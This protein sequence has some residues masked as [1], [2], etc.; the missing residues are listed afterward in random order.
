M[1]KFTLVFALILIVGF[2]AP[3]TSPVYT[4]SKQPASQE[5][6]QKAE[7]LIQKLPE[8][9]GN[10][11]WT[12]VNEIEKL[13]LSIKPAVEA[14]IKNIQPIIRLACSK[15]IYKIG[16]K[17]TGVKT[18]I[19]LID[20]DDSQK[21]QEMASESLS[22][23]IWNDSGY[24]NKE[25]ISKKLQKI[26]DET[27][28]P[29]VRLNLSHALYSTSHS[30]RAVA[31]LKNLIQLGETKNTNGELR[32]PGLKSESALTLAEIGHFEEVTEILKDLS[33]EPGEKGKRA[34]VLLD[35]KQYMDFGSK[36][37]PSTKQKYDYKILDE[38]LDLIKN[39]YVDPAK[40]N[41]TDLITA[42]AKGITTSLDRFSMYHTEEEKKASEEDLNKK[43]GGI[44]AYVSMRDNLLTI[45]RPIYSGPAY[46][47]GLRSLDKITEVGNINTHGKNIDELIKQLKGVPGTPVKIKV[48]RKGWTKEKEM[49]LLRAA[50]EIKTGRYAILPGDIGVLSIISFGRTTA[51]E[52]RDGIRELNKKNVKTIIIDLR[53]NSGGLLQSVLQIVD[54]FLEKG[55]EILTTKDKDGH[56]L[57]R[58]NTE[59]DNKIDLPVYI[60]VDNGSASASEIL[61]G[62]LQDYKKA[63]L[64]GEQTFG[65]GSVQTIF[66]L[67]S[68]TRKAA[69]RLTIAKYY[70]PS[71]RCIHKEDGKEGG[72][73]PDIKISESERDPWK[74]FAFNK[75]LESNELDNYGNLYFSQNKELFRELAEDDG[76][77]AS[78]YP[79]FRDFFKTLREKLEIHLTENDVRE[80]LREY[81]RKRVADEKG[82]EFI[83]DT[84]N[85]IQ[86][87]RAIVEAAK[88]AGINLKNIHSYKAFANKFD[89]KE[90]APK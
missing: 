22:G 17:E 88:D 58:F 48:Y 16:D 37:N 8:Y 5:L 9:S 7:K 63:K 64:I 11:F 73:E 55:K 56:I 54:M 4:Q 81:I 68:T 42:A 61:A 66:E 29:Y 80:I 13:G 15:I 39:N 65:K 31:E 72:L 60:L 12:K 62:V 3:I 41:V 59:D 23:L 40:F 89:K 51:A 71:G 44:G 32:Y 27:T 43:Y 74:D 82:E 78:R 46:K 24:G 69:L 84:Q 79:G 83:V 26:L 38:I 67:A 52:V 57:E 14:G 50:I 21:I 2:I 19:E 86:L 53:R 36:S 10:D 33:K 30:I 35:Y 70:L 77:N 85:D 6:T 1:K 87:Q 28:T 20:E 34:Q 76:L 75:V 47:A 49:T 25:E 45:E 90:D 18:L